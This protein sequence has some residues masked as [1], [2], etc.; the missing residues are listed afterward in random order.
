MKFLLLWLYSFQLFYTISMSISLSPK[1]KNGLMNTIG[2]KLVWIIKKKKKKEITFISFKL[3]LENEM[4]ENKN[5]IQD[6]IIVQ[7]FQL[8]FSI[9]FKILTPLVISIL[10]LGYVTMRSL[11]S[12]N[13]LFDSYLS[14]VLIIVV[15]SS[16]IFIA[17]ILYILIKEKKKNWIILLFVMVI[18][19]FVFAYLVFQQFLF[20]KIFGAVLPTL[21][22]YIYCFLLKSKVEKWISE[23]YWHQSKIEEKKEKEEKFKIGLL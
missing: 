7:R 16:I 6:I 22:Y 18:I 8:V 21:L 1:S 14:S 10:I 2:N 19:P 13:G 11:K 23:Y 9:Y 12:N 5:L 17:Y 3:G 4:I 15:S 20:F